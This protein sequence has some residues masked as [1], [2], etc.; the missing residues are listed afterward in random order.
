MQAKAVL[1]L[2]RDARFHTE[3]EAPRFGNIHLERA[4]ARVPHP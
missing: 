1:D 3:C 4:R 2:W